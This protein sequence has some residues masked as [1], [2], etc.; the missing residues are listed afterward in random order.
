MSKLEEKI[1]QK[2]QSIIDAINL[3][4]KEESEALKNRLIE[5]A[6]ADLEVQL[7]KAQQKAKAQVEQAKQEGMRALRDEVAISK[8]QLI[9]SIFVEL[10][11]ELKHL[12]K[13]DYFNYVV[14]SIQ[15]QAIDK[16]EEIQVSKKEYAM[17]QSILTTKK[18]D[19]VEADLLNQ[20]LGKDYQLKLSNKP[21][22]IESGFMLVGKLYDLNFSLENLLES[23]TKKYEKNIYEALN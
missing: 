13:E 15:N 20:K 10:K 19:L 3:S 17:Y 2:G 5:E 11:E 12:N 1:I 9:E 18:G 14:R 16:T 23:L 8:Q 7:H 4:A 21:A 22:Q 6:K